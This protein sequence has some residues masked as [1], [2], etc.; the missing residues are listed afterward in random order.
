ML[1]KV[2]L[3]SKDENICRHVNHHHRSASRVNNNTGEYKQIKCRY[4]SAE[5][6]FDLTTRND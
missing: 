1:Q 4:N 2:G 3:N 6:H 5:L